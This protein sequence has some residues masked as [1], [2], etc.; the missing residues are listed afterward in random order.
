ME[1]EATLPVQSV[2]LVGEAHGELLR[3]DRAISFWG[4]IDPQTGRIT[5]PRHPQHGASVGGRILAMERVVGSSSGSSVMM[6]LLATGMAPSGLILTEVDAILTLGV[7]VGREMGYGSIP[8]FLVSPETLQALPVWLLMTID[9][10][11]KCLDPQCAII[12]T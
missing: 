6:E 1:V 11:L 3:L 2:L 5:D 9:G 4:G 7:I 12:P 10:R 8:I